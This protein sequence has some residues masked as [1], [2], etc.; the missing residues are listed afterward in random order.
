MKKQELYN[1]VGH[2]G[3]DLIA[4][5]AMPRAGRQK[6]IKWKPLVAACLVLLLVGG[7]VGGYA[8][9]A[10]AAEYR[11]AVAFFEQNRLSTEGLT[12]EEIKA[13]YRD[14]TTATFSYEKTAQ[15]LNT[16]SVELYAVDLGT[17]DKQSLAAFWENR[18]LYGN[19]RYLQGKD[20]NVDPVTGLRYEAS[21][22]E[23]PGVER[24]L[25]NAVICYDGETV[26]WEYV[27]DC[28]FRMPN[29]LVLED[30][31]LFYEMLTSPSDRSGA[32]ALML[33]NRGQLIWEYES[34]DQNSRFHFVLPTEEGYA[35]FGS[36]KEGDSWYTL[37]TLLDFDGAVLCCQKTPENDSFTEYTA[38]AKIGDGYLAL[39]QNS[40]NDTALVF[41][42][43]AGE[44]RESRAY[45]D[46]DGAYMI[47]DMMYHNGK[48]WLSAY[49]RVTYAEH[50]EQFAIADAIEGEY[51]QAWWEKGEDAVVTDEQQE[52][53]T[54]AYRNI[55][56]AAL[57]ICDEGGEISKAY[58]VPGAR[59]IQSG[60]GYLYKINSLE[61]N[62]ND[63][64][65]WHIRR[66]DSAKPDVHF[67]AST[68]VISAII[69]KVDLL[70]DENTTLIGKIEGETY[71]NSF[72]SVLD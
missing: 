56:E 36:D 63:Q 70:F 47:H 60:G 4:K 9:A 67:A 40:H 15:V 8:F 19:N 23:Y 58:S 12:R 33:S 29:I 52:A 32:A 27:H 38:A 55:F 57:F 11:E 69:T 59:L 44:V 16:L 64:I 49:R 54:E 5:N 22:R 51:I 14:I 3:E 6:T 31:V 72:M 68:K 61:L 48:V 18:Y 39:R 66:L 50:R 28:A 53:Y 21:N 71:T 41:F 30:G 25:M 10:E 45:L 37:F 43:E 20:Q 7:S 17:Y 24:G 34:R 46:A 42:S 65:V 2:V 1:A 26:V 13:V 35:F 62:E